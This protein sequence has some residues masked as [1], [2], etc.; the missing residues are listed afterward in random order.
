M[1]E[2]LRQLDR[3]V[4]LLINETWTHPWLDVFFS[5]ITNLHKNPFFA[6]VGVLAVGYFGFRKFGW[7][8]WRLLVGLAL[9][10]A[11][12]DAF[13]YRVLKASID[14]PR[15]FQNEALQGR[16]VQRV[17]G[18]GNSFPSNHAVNCFGAATVL[19]FAFPGAGY[20]FYIFA[21]IVAYSR[22]YLGVH[23]PSDVL[24]GALLGLL[25]AWVVNH[26]ILIQ[27]KYLARPK[28]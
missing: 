19:A 28:S 2:W 23:Y 14:R 9:T 20:I 1:M 24:A 13:S 16:V 26:F 15:P 5:T 18:Y 10:I 17:A 25:V 7:R 8:A 4:L 27:L 21:A 3:E 11:I 12:G 6:A 22:I